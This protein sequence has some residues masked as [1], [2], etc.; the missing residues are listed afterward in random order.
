MIKK[1]SVARNSAGFKFQTCGFEPPLADGT[2]LKFGSNRTNISNWFEPRCGSEG[3]LANP[4]NYSLKSIK[5][6]GSFE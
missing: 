6:L 5:M 2:L 3:K 1:P 4:G